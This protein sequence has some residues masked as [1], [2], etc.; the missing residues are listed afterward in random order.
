[1]FTSTL[2]GVSCSKSDDNNGGD[3]E[4]TYTVKFTGSENANIEMIIVAK[5]DGSNETYS[6]VNKSSWETQVKSKGGIS[7]GAVGFTTDDKPGKLK[8][9]IIENGKVVKTSTSEGTVLNATVTN[10]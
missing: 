5:A 6:D 4:K 7:A 3:S 1:M 9:E 8:A 10:M 2:L